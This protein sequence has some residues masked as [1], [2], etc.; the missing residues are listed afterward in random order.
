MKRRIAI[1]VATAALL[2]TSASAH[3]MATGMGPVFDGIS[4]FGLSPEDF[5]PVIALGFFAGLRG[6]GHSRLTLGAVTRFWL[7][8]GMISLSGF[9]ASNLVLSSATAALFMLIGIALSANLTVPTAICAALGA[10]LGLVRGMADLAGVDGSVA[11]GLSLIGMTASVFAV[12]AMAAS[13]TIPLKRLWLVVAARV[14][15]S[16]IA[17]LGLLLVGWIVRYG[18][19]TR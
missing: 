13:L 12:F 10:S 15:G 11:H 4:H 3:L 9:A 2:P 19:F 8:G 7:A 14:G 16:W 6:P 1:A 5:L 17:A 18:A